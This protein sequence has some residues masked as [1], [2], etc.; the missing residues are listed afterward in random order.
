MT[1]LVIIERVFTSYR[2]PIFDYLQKHIDFKLL[3]GKNNSGIKTV[4]AS[5]AKPINSFQYAK[6][7][8]KV[9]LFPIKEILK[10]KPD[11]V[12]CDLAIGMLNLPV[13]IYLSKAFNIKFAFWS[14]GYNRKTGFNP[15][16]KLID[17]YRLFLMKL[18]DANIV[19]S[20]FDKDVILPY[21]DRNSVF[22][23]QNTLDTNALSRIRIELE[24]EGRTNIKQRL[25]IKHDF[26]LVFIGRMLPSKRP[27]LLVDL[28]EYLLLNCNIAVGI[29]FV[30]EGEVL[31]KIRT[32]VNRNFDK[33]DF[34]FHGAIHDYFATGQILF[35]NDLMINPGY[36]GLSVNHAFCF[37]CPVLSFQTKNGYPAHSPEVEY[38]I[39]NKTGFLLESHTLETMAIK[40]I[41]YLK[42]RKIQEEF[43]QNL[44]Y[45][46]ENTFPIEKMVN[47]LLECFE[48]LTKSKN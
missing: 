25:G 41:D 27:D 24:Q 7:E 44:K 2:K 36:L 5:Y 38:V 40:V 6:G 14:H 31:S 21:L 20:Q 16:N 35:V 47:G 28:Y 43:H 26:N 12:F 3:Y 34:Y 4:N 39:H 8:T 9:L 13:I 32:R 29:H 10:I 22:V 30:G 33:N 15:K 46:V 23:A 48:F 1:K 37:C 19:Y 45:A 18:V 11:V 42:N 17:K